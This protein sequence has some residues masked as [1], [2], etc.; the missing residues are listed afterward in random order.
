MSQEDVR[1]H[2]QRAV[3]TVIGS[4]VDLD[5]AEELFEEYQSRIQE[6]RLARGEA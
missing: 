4:D 5:D 3:D 6:L 2:L 1:L